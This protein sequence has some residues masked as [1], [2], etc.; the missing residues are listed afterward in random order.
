MRFHQAM[1]NWIRELVQP[2]RE[3]GDRGHELHG[4]LGEAAQVDPRESKGLKPEDHISG[5]SLEN[6][7]LA[8]AMALCYVW[9]GPLDSTCTALPARTWPWG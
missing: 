2:H 6:Q 9:V 5:S 3:G 8:S 1:V 4:H 7:A